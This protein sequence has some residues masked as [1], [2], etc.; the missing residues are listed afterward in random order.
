[1]TKYDCSKRLDKKH[2]CYIFLPIQSSNSDPVWLD[3]AL[4]E[5]SR[6][7]KLLLAQLLKPLIGLCN[8]LH[9]STVIEQ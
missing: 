1:M 7:H 4:T 3:Y 6:I 9:S 2:L 5:A 8:V